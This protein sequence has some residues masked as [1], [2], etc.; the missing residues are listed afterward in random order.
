MNSD[1]DN[2]TRS[3]AELERSGPP[4]AFEA[5]IVL[6]FH[7]GEGSHRVELESG[8]AVIVGRAFPSNLVLPD[9]SLSRQHACF[10][11]RNGELIVEDLG[12]RNGTFVG[13]RRIDSQVRVGF[14]ERIALGAA[15]ATVQQSVRGAA[16]RPEPGATEGVIVGG[17]A[18]QQVLQLAGRM[19]TTTAPVLILG[20]TGTGKDVVA[21][22][23]HEASP[24][25]PRPFRSINCAAIPQTLVETFLFGHE[26]G[27]FTGA[28]GTHKG[29]FEQ[30]ESGTL[31]LDE[32]AELSPASQAALL[33]A[34]ETQRITRVGG[35]REI[36]VDVRFVA[37]THRNLEQLVREE[38]FR[39]D[40]FFRLSTLQI[41]VPPL[42]E[43]RDEIAPLAR[44]FVA[45]AC[46]AWNKP[47]LPISDAAMTALSAHAFPGNV[48]ELRNIVERAVTIAEGPQIEIDDLPAVRG[49]HG[50]T[51]PSRHP[52]D[53]P[54]LPD[55]S[56]KS[57]LEAYERELIAEALQRAGGNKT[58]AA[59]L[60]RMP[61]RTLMRKLSGQE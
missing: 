31:F 23:I 21:R 12:S 6:V 20:E 45:R 52:P 37:A 59:E 24:R 10:R 51:R 41:A 2:P 8:A 19:A 44:H 14:G 33:R 16:P 17:A 42:R 30:A 43:R 36:E 58:R 38:K 32:I 47:L 13:N 7:H 34:I 40:L 48:R 9:P 11:H 54:A 57:R 29:V 27:A 53:D 35:S 4:T 1:S 55:A 60:L 56:H 50:E 3:T 39:A 18:M 15:V 49:D 61:L 22:L 5:S 25:K 26:R 46:A 28:S